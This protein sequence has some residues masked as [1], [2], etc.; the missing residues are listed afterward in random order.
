[1]MR[2]IIILVALTLA[3]TANSQKNDNVLKKN[4]VVNQE[5]ASS[6]ATDNHNFLRREMQVVTCRATNL[7]NLQNSNCNERY[8]CACIGS[9]ETS[10]S[11]CELDTAAGRMCLVSGSSITFMER[12]TSIKKT[13]S[14]EYFSGEA[15][16]SC[17]N[18]MDRAET[19]PLPTIPISVSPAPESSP[20]LSPPVALSPPPPSPQDATLTPIP[21]LAPYQPP[22]SSTCQATNPFN[23]YVCGGGGGGAH[24]PC[25]NSYASCDGLEYSCTCLSSPWVTSCSYCQIRTGNAIMCQV[26][27]TSITFVSPE[28]QL[29]TCSCNSNDGVVIQNC[30]IPTPSPVEVPTSDRA[31]TGTA[32]PSSTQPMGVPIGQPN[33]PTLQPVSIPTKT[34]LFD[35]RNDLP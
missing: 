11:Y 14:C 8:P 33:L 25:Q 18:T 20:L 15:R 7:A 17:Y 6:W 16:Q 31:P 3:I 32:P 13:C 10:C 26:V 35:S 29:K 28:S 5:L 34:K 27:G 1:M 22:A 9:T 23:V 2:Q 24:D 21:A 4:K 30:Y 12:G 19:E